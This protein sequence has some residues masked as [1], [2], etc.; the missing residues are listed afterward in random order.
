MNPEDVVK[1]S[2]GYFVDAELY[3]GYLGRAIVLEGNDVILLFSGADSDDL[4]G[5][6]FPSPVLPKEGLAYRGVMLRTPRDWIL[7][8]KVVLMEELGT[9]SAFAGQQT[10]RSGWTELCI[11]AD[12]WDLGDEDG[13][14]GEWA[15]P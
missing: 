3:D 14:I 10:A 5:V 2:E 9:G 12:H 15:D 13:V 1:E 4:F 8:L 7:D 6:R 11:P